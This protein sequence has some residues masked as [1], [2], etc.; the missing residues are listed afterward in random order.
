M[1]EE[2][3]GQEYT[4]FF[5]VELELF[6]GPIDLLLHLVK[7]NELP[8]EKISLAQVTEQYLHVIRNVEQF[9]LEIAGEYLVIAA[10][11]LSI[12]SSYL[13]NEPVQLVEDADGNL[14]D[15]HEELLYRLREAQ[16]YKEG[17]E[18]LGGLD[19]LG[20]H[21]FSP[22]SRLKHIKAQNRNFCRSQPVTTWKGIEKTP[23]RT[24]RRSQ[25]DLYS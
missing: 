12:K 9:D 21:V 8:I 14:I 16:V 7:S 4:H 1:T 22:P 6:N 13:L 25:H 19:L 18:M 11:L 3:T 2:V 15:P 23:G 10:T 20:V 17:A 5:E 24:G